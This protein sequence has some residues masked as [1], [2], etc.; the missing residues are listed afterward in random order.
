MMGREFRGC[1]V[2]ENDMFVCVG[3]VGVF[4]CSGKPMVVAEYVCVMGSRFVN[5]G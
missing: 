3:F 1:A 4:G 2:S 5:V